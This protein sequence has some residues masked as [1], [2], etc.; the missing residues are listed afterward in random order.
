MP[1]VLLIRHGDN[2]YAKKQRLAGRLPGIHLNEKG[3]AQAEELARALRKVPLKAVY[4]SPLERAVET[5][6]P[7]AEVHGLKVIK[8]AG[9]IE[10]DQGMWEGKSVKSLRRSKEWKSVHLRPSRFHHPGGESMLHQQMRQVEEIEAICALHK[11][12]DVIACVGHGDPIKLVIAHFIGL[13]LDHF[14]RLM[15]DTASV[16]TLLMKGEWGTMLLNLNWTA[17]GFGA[18]KF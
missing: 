18:K 14:Q 5:A 15:L 11:A 10:T 16:S 1:T 2:D 4:S 9:L 13:P 7:I 12:K 17:K 6:Q 8:R 3:R